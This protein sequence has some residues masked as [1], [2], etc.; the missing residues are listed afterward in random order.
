MDH[1]LNILTIVVL[2]SLIAFILWYFIKGKKLTEN[3][4]LSPYSTLRGKVQRII[5]LV[6][7]AAACLYIYLS[8]YTQ[9][10]SNAYAW[11]AAL[12]PLVAGVVIGVYYCNKK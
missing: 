3:I 6:A 4:Q 5:L 8:K 7:I 9:T 11:L 2:L 10:S 12:L 1:I